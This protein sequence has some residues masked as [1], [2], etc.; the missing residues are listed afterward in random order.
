MAFNSLN[1]NPVQN[2][3][4]A[5]THTLKR[6]FEAI[7]GDSVRITM[8]H[9]DD[10]LKLP[11]VRKK[12]FNYTKS[13]DGVE[14]LINPEDVVSRVPELH[15]YNWQR[16]FN[17]FI[18]T[19]SN[20]YYQ[21]LLDDLYPEALQR[22][23]Q[24]GYKPALY[25][26]TSWES[27]QGIFLLP[28]DGQRHDRATLNRVAVDL[29]RRYGDPR[30]NSYVH[31]FRAAGFMNQKPKHLRGNLRPIVKIITADPLRVSDRLRD[32]LAEAINL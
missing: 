28:I 3:E 12:S 9:P 32:D 21:F 6:Q 27:Y 5:I 14:T 15:R 30:I 13:R 11:D 7:G 17:V 24:D 19:F 16:G 18:T 23:A 20:Q 1:K 29:N 31:S 25:Q 22:M 4:R 10:D 8:M 2:H 26:Q